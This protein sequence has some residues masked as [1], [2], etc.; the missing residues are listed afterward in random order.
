MLRAHARTGCAR[1][2]SGRQDAPSRSIAARADVRDRTCAAAAAAA[3]AAVA[4]AAAAAAAAEAREGA[5]SRHQRR[6]EVSTHPRIITH[7]TQ[8]GAGDA[9]AR[10][11][12]GTPRARR[13]PLLMSA[14]VPPVRPI[15]ALSISW[16]PARAESHRCAPVVGCT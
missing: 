14:R 16:F 13:R 11:H 5:Q 3:A 10:P 12:V 15:I 1:C 6:S 2:T 9:R 4:A 7:C 8:Q